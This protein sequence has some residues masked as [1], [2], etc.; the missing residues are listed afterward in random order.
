MC[1]L[2]CYFFLLL[3]C[4]LQVF[5]L[6][7]LLVLVFGVLILCNFFL[8]P[9]PLYSKREKQ[10]ALFSTTGHKS[11]RCCLVKKVKSRKKKSKQT[12]HL[13]F[14]PHTPTS[15]RLTLQTLLI[16]LCGRKAE[17]WKCRPVVECCGWLGDSG[18]RQDWG[19]LCIF[20]NKVSQASV[21]K[22]LASGRITTSSG[23]G[24]SQGL[25]ARIWPTQVLGTQR[26]SSEVFG[27]FF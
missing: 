21:L 23:W 13:Y 18:R 14:L 16:Y 17:Q 20:T 5:V 11:S 8:S 10:V 9:F 7:L 12:T 2:F 6:F 24:S 3:L 15:Q 22:R 27:G 4:S 25:I 1:S 26:A 19:L